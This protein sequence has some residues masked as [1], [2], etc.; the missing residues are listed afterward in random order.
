MYGRSG[1]PIYLLKIDVHVARPST[2]STVLVTG[3]MTLPVACSHTFT[4]TQD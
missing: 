1:R 2:D 3:K 4:P